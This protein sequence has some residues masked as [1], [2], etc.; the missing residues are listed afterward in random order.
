MTASTA[1][2]KSGL[3]TSICQSIVNDIQTGR[4]KMYYF[5]G[6]S[7]EWNPTAST[8]SS[9]YPRGTYKY[10]LETR[11]NILTYKKILPGDVSFVVPRIDWTSGTV[12]DQYD[13]NYQQSTQVGSGQITV[14]TSSAIVTGI[15]SYFTSELAVGDVLKTYNDIEIGTI[16]SITSDTSLTLEA[17]SLIAATNTYYDY[18]HTHASSTGATSIETSRFYVITDTYNVYKCLNNNKGAASTL[19]PTGTSTGTITTADGYIWKFMLNIPAA[20]RNK[21]LTVEYIPVTVSLKNQFYS[22]GE[23]TAV[24]IIDG[25][26]GYSSSPAIT[27]AGD[28]FLADN[29]YIITG[30]TIIEAGAGYTSP[31]S[32]TVSDPTVISGS[33]STATMTCTISGDAVDAV[34]IT[35]AGYGYDSVPTITV[36]EPFA[37]TTWTELTAVNVS[38]YLKHNGNYYEV[39]VAGTTSIAAPTHT[40]GAV[41]NGSA[42]L[43]YVGTIAVIEPYILKT[44]ATMT[45]TVTA[46]VITDVTVTDGGVGYTYAVVTVTDSAGSG[47]EIIV[48]LTTGSIDTL[49]SSVELLSVDGGIHNIVVDEAGS[50]YSGSPSVTIVG[51]GTGAT[52]IASL[53]AVGGIDSIT[54]T[55]V[56]SGYTYATISIGGGGTGAVARAIIAPENGHGRNAVK[57]LY[58]KTLAFYNTVSIEKNQGFVV[59]NDYR[60]IGII[61][62]PN[63][64]NSTAKYKDN[65]GSACFVVTGSINTSNFTTDMLINIVGESK[66]FRI[67]AV[68]STQALLLSINNDVPALNDVFENSTGNTFIVTGVTNPTVDSYSG[69]L[70]FIDNKNAFTPSSS[71]SITA[72]TIIQF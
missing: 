43:T 6:K 59:N 32:L 42:E 18:V 37:G 28:G 47:A 62:N 30:T 12:Y 11:S 8:D 44:E 5:L 64:Y 29:P 26:S 60:Q 54:I 23:I 34:A 48:D 53:T 71:Q 51:D 1:T 38:D 56:G 17:N 67:V 65:L 15:S 68:T 33:E 58:A 36:D 66:E 46:G 16:A 50:G 40:S 41:T 3:R 2:I 45:A 4:S 72:R 31:P 19:K 22:G 24:N 57:E 14:S 27:V 69:D 21:F 9:Q 25:G 7:L 70:F 55:D 13:D 63:I 49:Q 20:L 52:A 10:E 39:T 35:S 61:N